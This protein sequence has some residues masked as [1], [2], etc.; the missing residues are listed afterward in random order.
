MLHTE[1]DAGHSSNICGMEQ[2]WWGVA[3]RCGVEREGGSSAS[4]FFFFVFFFFP[5]LYAD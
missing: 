3:G 4:L 1:W 2:I 5:E